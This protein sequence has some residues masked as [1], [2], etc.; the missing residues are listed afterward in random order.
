MKHTPNCRDKYFE[1]ERRIL[2]D[3]VKVEVENPFWEGLLND[4]TSALVLGMDLLKERMENYIS[5]ME[6]MDVGEQ[7]KEYGVDLKSIFIT[8]F[9]TDLDSFK[10]NVSYNDQTKAVV[11]AI[12]AIL[13]E[14]EDARC[15]FVVNRIESLSNDQYD[16]AFNQAF[17]KGFQNCVIARKIAKENEKKAS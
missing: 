7:L 5:E 3:S 14:L 1:V 8:M 10:K 12:H 2:D 4:D 16:Y 17:R 15:W 11:I 13:K 9:F 6:N